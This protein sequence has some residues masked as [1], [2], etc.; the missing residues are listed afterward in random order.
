MEPAV[1]FW[2]IAAVVA[3]RQPSPLPRPSVGAVSDLGWVPDVPPAARRHV[4]IPLRGLVP[5]AAIALARE[6]PGGGRA[7][8][9]TAGHLRG[10]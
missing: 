6:T 4:A 10:P 1:D 3:G 2:T 8:R 7:Q 9:P 5:A